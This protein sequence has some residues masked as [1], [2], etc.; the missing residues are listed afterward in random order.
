MWISP[1]LKPDIHVCVF[2][3]MCIGILAFW[4]KEQGRDYTRQLGAR[5]EF[6]LGSKEWF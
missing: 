6:L 1:H 5:D 2:L 3:P 4:M